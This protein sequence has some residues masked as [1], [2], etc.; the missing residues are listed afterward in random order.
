MLQRVM[1]DSLDSVNSTL[2]AISDSILEGNDPTL[3]DR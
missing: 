1:L 3:I 2:I